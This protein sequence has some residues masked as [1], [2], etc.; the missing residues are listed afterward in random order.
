MA[1][2][3]YWRGKW[4][5]NYS[6]DHRNYFYSWS[7]DADW[8]VQTD[9]LIAN[10]TPVAAICGDSLGLYRFFLTYQT[11]NNRIHRGQWQ[12]VFQGDRFITLGANGAMMLFPLLSF[13]GIDEFLTST[14]STSHF[15]HHD[16][17]P[18]QSR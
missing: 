13:I 7:A 1:F 3:F 10:K 2:I 18:C 4:N 14:G 6:L 15:H 16:V 5:E 8:R 9:F 17:Y 11:F 12:Q